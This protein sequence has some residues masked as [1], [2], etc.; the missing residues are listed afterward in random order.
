VN[1]ETEKDNS[2]KNK[3][4]NYFSNEKVDQLL[5]DCLS[6]RAGLLIDFNDDPTVNQGET[7]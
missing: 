2:E 1:N 6:E 5:E 3:D 4:K 7:K